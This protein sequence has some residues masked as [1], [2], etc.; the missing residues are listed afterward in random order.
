M[1]ITA[2][3]VFGN[4]SRSDRARC[5]LVQGLTQEDDM[6]THETHAHTHTHTSKILKKPISQIHL[7]HTALHLQHIRTK[8]HYA[9][10]RN[11]VILQH[12]LQQF[13][14]RHLLCF[15]HQTVN[16]TVT[17]N[18]FIKIITYAFTYTS[19]VRII[20]TRFSLMQQ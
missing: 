14:G 1:N 10:Y 16:V 5:W 20:S 6:F 11:A 3:P 4:L 13:V 17:H 18:K 15:V 7:W 2:H 9:V 12:T 8:F 19:Y